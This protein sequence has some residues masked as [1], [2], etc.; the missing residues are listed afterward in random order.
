MRIMFE[1]QPVSTVAVTEV[2]ELSVKMRPSKSKSLRAS[3]PKE[4]ALDARR[5]VDVIR[6]E[7]PARPSI[8]ARGIFATAQQRYWLAG[9]DAGQEAT[10]VCCHEGAPC[11]GTRM[12][13]I[14]NSSKNTMVA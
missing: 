7:K 6:S 13:E 4:L 5:R 8:V 10:Y 11:L 1:S 9:M 12:V 14:S 3:S 2:R